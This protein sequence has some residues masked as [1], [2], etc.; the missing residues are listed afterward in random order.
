MS[1]CFFLL[2]LTGTQRTNLVKVNNLTKPKY[3]HTEHAEIWRTAPQLAKDEQILEHQYQC[4]QA[5]SVAPS[6]T[7][8]NTEDPN[9]LEVHDDKSAAAAR[10]TH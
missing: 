3:H 10:P 2:P 8:L 1:Y 6:I 4:G 5:E 7:A 9:L